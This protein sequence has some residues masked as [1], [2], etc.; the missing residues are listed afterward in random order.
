MIRCAI[1]SAVAISN[2]GTDESPFICASIAECS[3]A[4]YS[5]NTSVLKPW[6]GVDQT[7]VLD[8]SSSGLY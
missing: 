5:T 7:T 1:V 8:L 3:T 6:V 2:T 4:V